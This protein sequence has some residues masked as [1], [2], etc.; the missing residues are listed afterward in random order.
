MRC[1][2]GH[3]KRAVAGEAAREGTTAACRVV[4]LR[5]ETA[6]LTAPPADPGK[7][8]L[9]EGLR[10]PTR[11]QGPTRQ[12]AP[13]MQADEPDTGMRHD[14]TLPS[15][16]TTMLFLALCERYGWEESAVATV[17]RGRRASVPGLRY[18]DDWLAWNAAEIEGAGA[19]T[20]RHGRKTTVKAIGRRK[21]PMIEEQRR[22]VAERMRKYWAARRA[23]KAEGN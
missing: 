7:G 21:R 8:R 13:L 1:R 23:E 22:A 20:A 3:A 14:D 5:L 10:G 19:P 16:E 6:R 4:R 18:R 12:A 11:V 17:V 9:G 15:V 2:H